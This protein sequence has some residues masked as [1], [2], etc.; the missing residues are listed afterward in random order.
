MYP[1]ATELKVGNNQLDS[2]LPVRN[3]NNDISWQFVTGLALS[4]ALKRKIEAYDPDQFRED[5]KTHMQELL[6][7][8]AFWSVLRTDVFFQSGYFPC[9]PSFLLFHAQFV[10]EK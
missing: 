8:P 4:Y 10:G 2:Y 3:K 7:E 5:C 9:I 1:I 6:D